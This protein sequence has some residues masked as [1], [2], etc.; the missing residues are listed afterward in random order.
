VPI[1][2]EIAVR[3][4]LS[5]GFRAPSLQQLWFSNVSSVFVADGNGVLQPNQIKTT[6]NADPITRNAF[7]I[8]KLKQETSTN[9][10]AGVTV[11]MFD[12]LS[13]TADGYFIRL[14]NRITLTNAF[15]STV[16][17]SMN[18][19]PAGNAIFGILAMYPGVTGAQF[20]ANAVDTDTMGAD[21][22]GDYALHTGAGTVMFGAALNLSKTEVEQVHTPSTLLNAFQDVEA[23][24]LRNLFFDRLAQNRL[25]DAVPHV[26]GNASVRYNYKQLSA[27][28]RANYYGQVRIKPVIVADSETF[29]AKMLFDL[30]VGYQLT[31]NLQLTVGADNVFN[32]FPDQNQKANNVSLGR[33]V[34]N[35]NVTQFGLNGGFYYGKL[36]LTFF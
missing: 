32:T 18:Q 10:S 21:I 4:A 23:Q 22:V 36:E 11:R 28:V 34:Y 14:K 29:G 30:D 35:R 24:A 8:P 1:N 2:K 20:F 6:N 31:K 7:G 5:T 13:L 17:G 25:E 33:F 9:A 16:P 12:N 15:Q 19:T 26:K 3:G 27:L